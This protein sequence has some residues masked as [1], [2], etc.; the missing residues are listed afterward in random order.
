MK[1]EKAPNKI[2]TLG[3]LNAGEVFQFERG[4]GEY[5]IKANAKALF[6]NLKSGNLS[7]GLA[8]DRVIHYPNAKMI[9]GDCV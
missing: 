6:L 5:H 8:F 9:P 3:D 4:V 1:I 2:I 7:E